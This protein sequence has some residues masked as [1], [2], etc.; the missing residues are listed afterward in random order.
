MPYGIIVQVY[1][2]QQIAQTPSKL[3]KTG[4]FISQ[5][6]TN[7]AVNTLSLLTQLSDLT[8][9]INNSHTNASLVWSSSIVT[10]TTG[11]PHG[12]TVADTLSVTILGVTPAGYNGT[13]TGTVTGASTFT[14]P[15]GINPGTETIP[16]AYTLEDV[17]EL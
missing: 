10:V 4:A 14:Y 6:A 7:T 13:F 17:S 12:F 9:L 2:S 11:A 15:L 1:V 3:Q 8:T 5:G 16:G